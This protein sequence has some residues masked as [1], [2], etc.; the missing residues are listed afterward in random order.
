MGYQITMSKKEVGKVYLAMSMLFDAPYN[1]I[2]D[3]PQGM[4]TNSD[5]L[6]FYLF[7]PGGLIWDK[8]WIIGSGNGLM[9]YSAT[10]REV[11]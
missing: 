8:K 1:P 10:F 11:I 3:I 2:P 6:N 7:T 5:H 9:V 4:N